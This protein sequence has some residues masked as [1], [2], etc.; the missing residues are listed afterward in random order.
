MTTLT[1]KGKLLFWNGLILILTLVALESVMYFST[2]KIL[3]EAVYNKLRQELKE[4]SQ[5]I[6]PY[7][8][9]L[10][11]PDHTEW[12][13][14]EHVEFG[15]HAIYLQIFAGNGEIIKVSRNLEELDIRF[16]FHIPEQKEILFHI[17]KTAKGDFLSGNFPVY[18]RGRLA[19][20]ITAAYAL[21]DLQTYLASMRWQ[22]YLLSPICILLALAGI[23]VISKFSL[24]PLTHITSTAKEIMESGDLTQSLPAARADREVT[25]LVETLNQLFSRLNKSMTQISNFAA[26]ASHEL[27][28]PLTIARGHLEVA[29]SR[30]RSTG[31]YQQTLKVIREEILKMTNIIN[32]LLLTARFDSE[33]FNLDMQILHLDTLLEEYLPTAK[34]LCEDKQIRLCSQIDHGVQIVG[35][36]EMIVHL[37]NNLVENAVKY[38][39][40]DG[41]V[42]IRATQSERGV[43]LE[44][45]DT[46]IGVEPEELPRIFDRFY[47]VD[48]TRVRQFGGSGLG[49]SIVKWI[50]EKHSAQ[51]EVESRPGKGSLFRIVFQKIE[52]E[53]N[54]F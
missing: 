41:A 38:N 54:T 10:T 5:I 46:G 23:W 32:N 9:V 51:I 35:N 42:T 11:S 8:G 37:L 24:R 17:E 14:A 28:T 36:R 53:E 31:D 12:K 1:I 40:I 7:Q 43:L 18:D 27:R 25:E 49:L 45:E 6:E 21:T 26:D 44:V 16:S 2:K 22:F 3:Y 4:L 33:N 52:Y 19:G 29:L 34:S 20:V 47:R 50:V 30:P 48:K 13:E 39:H 15:E